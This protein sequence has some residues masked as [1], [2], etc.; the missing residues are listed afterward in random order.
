MKNLIKF[1]PFVLFLLFGIA[2]SEECKCDSLKEALFSDYFKARFRDDIV[3]IIIEKMINEKCLDI[4]QIFYKFSVENALY[5]KHSLRMMAKNKMNSFI[6]YLYT[7]GDSLD[8]P[9]MFACLVT[10]KSINDWIN[11]SLIDYI[12]HLAITNVDAGTRVDAVSCLSRFARLEDCEILADKIGFEPDESVL[13]NYYRA[14]VRFS[15]KKIDSVVSKHIP[16]IS[17]FDRKFFSNLEEYNRYDFLPELYTLRERLNKEENPL[18][19]KDV[20]D[21]LT[22]LEEV[23]PNLEKK[24]TEKAPIGLPLDWGIEKKDG[25]VKISNK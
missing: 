16:L 17:K 6:T 3:E 19:K 7:Y 15:S 12:T 23:I 21:M 8:G 13:I 25:K 4:E 10:L 24:K 20:N 5:R 2:Y 1:L 22:K 14:L 9:T 11:D 18:M